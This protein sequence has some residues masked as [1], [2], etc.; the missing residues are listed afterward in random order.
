MKT[1]DSLLVAEAF[2]KPNAVMPRQS[3]RDGAAPGRARLIG[4]SRPAETARCCLS[5]T[6]DGR[7]IHQRDLRT[8]DDKSSDIGAATN[9]LPSACDVFGIEREPLGERLRIAEVPG[10]NQL[11]QDTF[12]H[13]DCVHFVRAGRFQSRSRRTTLKR[14]SSAGA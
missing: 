10:I 14:S 5:I 11:V 6:F 3:A 2:D 12:D 4:R 7:R 8:C 1:F 13:N 9:G